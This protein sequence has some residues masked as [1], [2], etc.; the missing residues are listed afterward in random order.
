MPVLVCVPITARK[1]ATTDALASMGVGCQT[2]QQSTDTLLP[3]QNVTTW[4]QAML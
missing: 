2:V 1:C 3:V 4:S